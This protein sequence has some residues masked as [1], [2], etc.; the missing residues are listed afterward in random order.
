MPDKPLRLVVIGSYGHVDVVLKDPL[1]AGV[2]VVAAA[3]WGP[4]D[5]L[6]FMGKFPSAPSAPSAPAGPASPAVYDDYREMLGEVDADI[7]AVFM[8][9]YRNAEASIAA[10]QAGCHIISEKPLAT[11]L[12][13][14]ARLR[15]AVA[16]AGVHI[17]AAFTGRCEAPF[18]SVRNVVAEGRIGEP[19]LASAQKSYP[20]ARRDDFYKDRRTYGGSIPWQA[21][22]AIDMVTYCT[23]K[24]FSRVA[25]MASNCAHPSHPAMEDN[26]GILLEFAAG[27]HAVIRFDY[28]RPWGRQR[29]RW[30]DNRLRIAGTQ[31][32]VE[33]V[34]EGTRVVLATPDATQPVPLSPPRDLLASFA[35]AVRGR[36]E[37]VVTGEDSFRITEVA[38]KARQAADTGQ[39]VAL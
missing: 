11:T 22:H 5:P 27:G 23:G 39:V 35:G 28:L 3:R 29:R 9:L 1:A 8:P 17:A 15:E 38:L 25:A 12:D 13:D 2:E 34:D 4:D 31:G 20:F 21:I 32:T 7:A 36:G 10:A 24:D 19:V 26:G 14:L 18:Q 16:S 33:V 37:C 30:G 6:S